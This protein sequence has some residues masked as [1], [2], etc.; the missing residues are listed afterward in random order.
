MTTWMWTSCLGS[1]GCNFMGFYGILTNS[2]GNL[3][4][5]NQQTHGFNMGLTHENEDLNNESWVVTS[6]DHVNLPQTA[7]LVLDLYIDLGGTYAVSSWHLRTFF[8][9][10]V[11]GFVR[12]PL[13]RSKP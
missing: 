9:K 1:T 2:Y 10:A 13:R 5:F 3:W 7:S 11:G 6:P 8:S 12:L 4:G